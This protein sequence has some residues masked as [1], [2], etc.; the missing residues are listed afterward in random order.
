MWRMLQQDEP[1]DMVLATGRACTVREFA[2]MA[3]EHVG[4]D[5]EEHVRVDPRYERP[6]EVD[7]LIGDASQ[8]ERVLGWKASVLAPELAQLMVD[9]DM[10]QLEDER[11]GRL[12]RLDR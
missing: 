9:A 12:V 1:R 3:F 5:W 6:A 2:R 8:A 11:A 7:A 4:L 10:Q